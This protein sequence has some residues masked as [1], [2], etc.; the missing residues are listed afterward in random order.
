M[1]KVFCILEG[2]DR[3]R[4]R[5]DLCVGHYFRKRRGV[6]S[7][8]PL[9]S[10]PLKIRVCK[11]E[12]CESAINA[13]GFCT[14]HYMRYRRGQDLQA[15]HR[16]EC[17]PHRVVLK[18]ATSRGAGSASAPCTTV[19]GSA[20]RIST[21]PLGR[22]LAL[23]P[24][25]VD[26]CDTRHEAL[27][28]CSM[29]YMRQV[30][31][32]P[33]DGPRREYHPRLS[34]SQEGCEL[35]TKAKGLCNLH[36]TRLRRGTPLE[37]ATPRLPQPRYCEQHN[38]GRK[39]RAKG[40][41]AMHYRRK[42]LGLSLEAPPR[43]IEG[44]P[45][46]PARRRRCGWKGCTNWQHQNGLCGLHFLRRKH[47]KQMDDGVWERYPLLRSLGLRAPKPAGGPLSEISSH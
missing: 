41:C 18:A 38:C 6:S 35:I 34:C 22:E 3:L 39:H 32:L 7:E 30:R 1:D 47:G 2:C 25:T 24:C 40:L 31:G 27:G 16:Y 17:P 37:G 12:G 45:K 11:I 33:M 36:Y 46:N 42:K 15:P 28:L 21:R 9:R 20:A 23:L 4:Y 29:H 26:G 19:A 5:K 44:Q 14:L 13:L 43:Y 10:Y 8:E